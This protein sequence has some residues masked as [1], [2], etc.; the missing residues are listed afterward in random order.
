MLLTDTRAAW[1]GFLTALAGLPDALVEGG[2][3][4]EPVRCVRAAQELFLQVAVDRRSGARPELA[5]SPL[6]HLP[7]ILQEVAAGLDPAP[8]GLAWALLCEQQRDVM[9]AL[10]EPEV[11]EH[12][13][14]AGL[15]RALAVETVREATAALR[16]LHAGDPPGLIF[17]L[18]PV[19]AW[20]ARTTSD[21]RPASLEVEGFVHCTREPEV[22]ESVA[23]LFFAEEP[24]PLA[25]VVLDLARLASGVRWEGAPHAFPHVYGPLNP[26][27]VRDVRLMERDGEGAW[28]FPWA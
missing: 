16:R 19:E 6:D 23:G 24:G 11:A 26:E 12:P 3:A 15:A 20:Q 2:A 7:R 4:A 5:R 18:V 9:A 25:L 1:H 28:R 17:H 14:A 22:L 13:E 27:A 8:A 21:Y 10:E